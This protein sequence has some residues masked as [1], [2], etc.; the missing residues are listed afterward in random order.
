[1]DNKRLYSIITNN[2]QKNS[3]NYSANE[4]FALLSIL[5]LLEITEIYQETKHVL[6]EKRKPYSPIANL[7]NLGNLAGLLS[8][9][10]GSEENN[11]IQQILPMLMSAL[12]S[13]NTSNLDP[14][15]ITNLLNSLKKEASEINNDQVIDIQENDDENNKKKVSGK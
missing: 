6:P 8:Q 11:S 4:I 5:V 3:N 1:M 13:N 15:K 2:L 9:L 14:G 12:G 10:Q 7:G